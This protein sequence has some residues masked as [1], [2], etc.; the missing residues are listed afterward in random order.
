MTMAG[1]PWPCRAPPLRLREPLAGLALRVADDARARTSLWL[2]PSS[3]GNRPLSA[4]RLRERLAAAGVDRALYARNGALSALAAQLPPALLADQLGLSLS[5]ARPVVQS[6]GGGS[7]RLRR[8]TSPPYVTGSGD[9]STRTR[10]I[11]DHRDAGKDCFIDD[12][13]TIIAERIDQ[14]W[15][16]QARPPSRP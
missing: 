14:P 3:Q 8:A 11:H 6:R 15:S 16:R 13:R 5:A 12:I 2:F 9:P 4:D 7:Q 10:G 1:L